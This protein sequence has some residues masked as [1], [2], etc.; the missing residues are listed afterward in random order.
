MPVVTWLI[1]PVAI[2]SVQRLSHACFDQAF[3]LQICEWLLIIVKVYPLNLYMDTLWKLR[4]IHA[5]TDASPAFVGY[6]AS[7]EEPQQLV[8]R[9]CRRDG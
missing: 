5:K 8:D 7:I 1:L 2:R 4:L 9:L 6:P 3:D